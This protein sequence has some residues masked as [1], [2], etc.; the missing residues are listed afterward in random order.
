[1]LHYPSM[2]T[3]QIIA[4]LYS[5]GVTGLCL[6]LFPNFFQP[7]SNGLLLKTALLIHTLSACVA[8]MGVMVWI[9]SLKK[10]LQWYV[11]GPF[12]GFSL[13][14]TFYVFIEDELTLMT[15]SSEWAST[16]DT[17]WILIVGAGMGLAV[18]LFATF[19][20]G[21]GPQTLFSDHNE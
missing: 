9:P 13:M 14:L 6:I 11:R 12:M 16:I 3:R 8:L 18:D 17:A 4:L 10:P 2:R 19:Y 5:M 21:E 15:Q 20:G 7:F 1:M